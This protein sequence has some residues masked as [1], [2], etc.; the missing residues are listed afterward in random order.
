MNKL[1]FKQRVDIEKYVIGIS[2]GD[3]TVLSRAITLVESTNK[4]ELEF[5][6]ELIDRLLVRAGN[7]IRIGITGVPGVGKSSFINVLG[8]YLTSINK[9]IAVLAI[10]PSS[11]KTKGSILGDKTRMNDLAQDP[12]AFIRPT[13][14]G[15]T[16]GGVAD[17]TREVILLCEAAGFDVIIVETVGVGQAETTVRGM[18]DF[19]L[20]LLLAGAGDELQG[21]KKGIME[22]VD[23]IAITKAD[24]ENVKKAQRAAADYQHALH[25]LA[26]AESG[27]NPKVLSTSALKAKGIAEVWEMILKYEKATKQSGFFT[28]Q[29]EEQ[30]IEWFNMAINFL[31]HQNVLG[32]REFKNQK[33]IIERKIAANKLTPHAGAT[34]IVDQFFF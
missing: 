22:M 16:L 29:R 30:S 33:K 19:F 9:R 20:L 8:T 24:G 11:K 23:G 28:K 6:T 2:S 14:A 12:N 1:I 25:I 13:P 5:A 15:N 10:D 26:P 34:Q 4:K 27:W 7:S 21:I 3:R 17:K 32:S 31:I 18:V